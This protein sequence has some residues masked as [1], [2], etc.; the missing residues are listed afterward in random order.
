[1]LKMCIEYDVPRE[2]MIDF[3]VNVVITYVVTIIT[4]IISSRLSIAVLM[5]W[6][7]SKDIAQTN[8]KLL[9]EMQRLNESLSALTTSS[10]VDETL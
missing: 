5:N 2:V 3:I 6:H 9:T 8:R 7:F 10:P 4:Y 1:M